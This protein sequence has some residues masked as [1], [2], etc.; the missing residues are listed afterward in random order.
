MRQQTLTA[1]VGT[2]VICTWC[3][4]Q[5]PDLAAHLGATAASSPC[6]VMKADW[7]DGENFFLDD[8]LW[9]DE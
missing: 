8:D 1:P 5:V 2:F 9:S 4:K 7:L 6:R 3:D